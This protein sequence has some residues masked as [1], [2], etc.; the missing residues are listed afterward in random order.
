[1]SEP[2]LAVAPTALE[3]MN[4]NISQSNST[5][6]NLFPY[7]QNTYS[8][9]I[10]SSSVSG[11]YVYKTVIFEVVANSTLFSITEPVITEENTD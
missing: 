6:L 10:L 7:A 5:V 1:V 4:Y 3:L 9:Y 11:R 2:Q 8:F